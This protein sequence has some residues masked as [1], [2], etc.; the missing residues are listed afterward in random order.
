[1]ARNQGYNDPP[2]NRDAKSKNCFAS[3]KHSNRGRPAIARL[4]QALADGRKFRFVFRCDESVEL[5]E[6]SI[7]QDDSG[8]FW[9]ALDR[10]RLQ[11]GGKA[12]P[13]ELL[14]CEY[15]T[16]AHHDEKD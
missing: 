4:N 16:C 14:L 12:A 6:Q 2:E 9:H 11:R 5:L 8:A 7:L 10:Q 13:K 1:M 15:C 3:I